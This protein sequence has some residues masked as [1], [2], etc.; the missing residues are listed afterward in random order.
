MTAP[1]GGGTGGFPLDGEP[2]WR[3]FLVAV[4][5]FRAALRRRHTYSPLRNPYFLFGL[6]W[7]ACLPLVLLAIHGWSVGQPIAPEQLV[8]DPRR[9]DVDYLY[10]ACPALFAV[11]F[12]ALGTIRYEKQAMATR[13]IRMLDGE[14]A[15]RTR[16]LFETY[17]QTVLALSQAIEAKDPYTRGHC[18][19]VWEFAERAALHLG[20][21]NGELETLK[22]ACFLHDVGK[23][24]IPGRIL[25]KPGPLAADELELVKLHP[26]YS[27]RIIAPIEHF[28][29]VA[30]LV[31][32]HHERNDG[33]GYPDGLRGE[34]LSLP[35]K[36]LI[37][38]DAMDAMTSDRPYR[39]GLPLPTAIEEL[40]RCA[41]LEYDARLLPN[42]RGPADQFDAVVVLAMVDGLVARPIPAVVRAPPSR[43]DLQ[44]ADYLLRAEPPTEANLAAARRQVQ[45]LPR[46]KNCWEVFGCGRNPGGDHVAEL[47]ICPTTTATSAD[48]LNGGLN[49]GRICWTV[50]GTLCAVP[51]NPH[52][53]RGPDRC[54]SCRF[55]R[56]VRD[57]EG[58]AEFRL[59]MPGQRAEGT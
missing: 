35:Q 55:Y 1:K 34:Q 58:L 56:Q 14:V 28:R 32:H 52:A 31:R 18:F 43:E 4:G 59:L 30:T 46:R 15:A 2:A 45:A 3:T 41:R 10:L 22:F 29:A 11:I 37:A 9:L 42:D 7:G 21:K 16:E 20:I 36:V 39:P 54:A 33:T 44:I 57:E 26:G 6:L 50:A 48:G 19:R 5:E 12:G 8:P 27:E 47:G 17:E 51:G 23:I 13:T 53:H 40:K 38:A 49:G 24:H 25:N